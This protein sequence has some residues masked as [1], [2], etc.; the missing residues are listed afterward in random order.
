MTVTRYQTPITNR[1]PQAPAEYNAG[2]FNNI[3]R[4]IEDNFNLI[5]G[6]GLVRAGGIFLVDPP[7][8]GAGLR[9]GEVY[10]DGEGYL[11][12]VR[13]GDIF[14]GSVSASGGLGT[15]TVLTP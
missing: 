14:L 11:R 13:E 9:P 2:S 8:T 3:V 4:V 6:V 10:V 15:L 12:M 7:R 1:V 5:T